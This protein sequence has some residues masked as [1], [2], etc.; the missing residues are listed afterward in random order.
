MICN[1]FCLMCDILI[2]SSS[3]SSRGSAVNNTDG[4]TGCV[5]VVG[6]ARETQ[7]KSSL[8]LT[9]QEAEA[10]DPTPVQAKADAPPHRRRFRG[11]HAANQSTAF[12]QGGAATGPPAK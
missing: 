11:Q 8:F 3:K 1:T 9:Q 10:A 4:G 6:F 12:V 5:I 2:L 7:T